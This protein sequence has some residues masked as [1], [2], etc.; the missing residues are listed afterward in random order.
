[1]MYGVIVFLCLVSLYL[2]MQKNRATKDL[3]ELQL[4]FRE[5]QVRL[6]EAGKSKLELE[7]TTSQ[8]L[9]LFSQKVAVMQQEQMSQLTTDTITRQSAFWS[10]NMTLIDQTLGKLSEKLGEME[11][12]RE[13][14]TNSLFHQLRSIADAEQ[15]LRKETQKVVK[16]LAHP[17]IRGTWGELHLKRVVELAGL[18][19]HVDF[20]EQVTLKGSEGIQRPD[21]VIHLPKDRKVFVDAKA[22]M[23]AFLELLDMQD[24]AGLQEKEKELAKHFRLHVQKLGKKEYWKAIEDSADFVVLFL[25]S[26]AILSAALK[27]DAS[28]YEFALQLGVILATPMTLV[29]LLR[30]IALGWRDEK[31]NEKSALLKEEVAVLMRHFAQLSKHLALLGKNLEKGVESYNRF[32]EIYKEN[33]L[34]RAPLFEHAGLA[35]EAYQDIDLQVVSKVFSK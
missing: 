14:Q 32:A 23:Q 21:L 9:E 16:A 24:E 8:L 6:E 29:A 35:K 18:V 12:G 5:A 7:I 4:L 26:D 31:L 11:K 10:Q 33:I 17:A 34:S 22:P 20:N 3:M 27:A 2:Y 28:L 19:E 25:P 13:G 30:M 1:M 15:S